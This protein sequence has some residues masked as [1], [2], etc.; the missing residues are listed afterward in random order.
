MCI[1]IALAPPRPP[2][3]LISLMPADCG[4]L[5]RLALL[6]LCNAAA[7]IQSIAVPTP[8]Q[9]AWQA[10][11]PEHIPLR[12][13]HHFDICTFTGCEHNSGTANRSAVRSALHSALHATMHQLL[14]Q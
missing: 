11:S 8:A 12:T 9:L 3:L 14:L 4:A 6:L 10:F 7:S 13:F 2:A 5:L 1:G